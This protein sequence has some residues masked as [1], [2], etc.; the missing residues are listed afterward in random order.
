M[1]CVN[2]GAMLVG[3]ASAAAPASVSVACS[4]V[5]TKRSARNCALNELPGFPDEANPDI[6]ST[7]SGMRGLNT[8]ICS[9]KAKRQSSLARCA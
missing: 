5:R 4:P 7:M 8:S 1:Y 9:P 2:A 3:S 6:V